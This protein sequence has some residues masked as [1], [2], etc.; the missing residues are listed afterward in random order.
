MKQT[1]LQES[2]LHRYSASRHYGSLLTTFKLALKHRQ[3]KNQR[4]RIILFVG[5]P[6]KAKDSQLV[7][8]GKRLK[9]NNVSVDVV[10][11]GESELNNEKLESFLNAVNNNNTRL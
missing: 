9:R 5:S 7:A 1:L 4:Q 8:L 6:I 3:N 2:E 11:F 10:N